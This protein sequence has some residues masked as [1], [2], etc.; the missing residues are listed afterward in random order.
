MAAAPREKQCSNS[1]AELAPFSLPMLGAGSVLLPS[2]LNSPL[3]TTALITEGAQTQDT[4]VFL[5][6]LEMQ[7]PRFYP[8]PTESDSLRVGPSHLRLS[9]TSG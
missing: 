4:A 6:V 2:D 1:T 9:R 7:I 5:G 3:G 8:R